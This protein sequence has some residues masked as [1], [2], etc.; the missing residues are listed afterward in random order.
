M[1]DYDAYE[2]RPVIMKQLARMG[3]ARALKRAGLKTG[4]TVRMG[5]IELIWTEK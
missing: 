2:S 3:A 4:D 5:E 1:V